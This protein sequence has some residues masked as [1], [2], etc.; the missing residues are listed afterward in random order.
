MWCKI[1]IIKFQSIYLLIAYT[2][3]NNL[4]HKKA[5]LNKVGRQREFSQFSAVLRSLKWITGN[6]GYWEEKKN[7]WSE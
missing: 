7:D 1:M 4:P 5:I 2:F 6:N 3:R